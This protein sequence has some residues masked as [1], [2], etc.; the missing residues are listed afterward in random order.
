MI[1]PSPRRR[2]LFFLAGGVS[3]QAAMWVQA[4]TVA[5]VGISFLETD[6]AEIDRLEAAA[7][8]LPVLLVVP[9]GVLADRVRRGSALAVLGLLNA[10]VLASLS[11]AVWFQVLTLPHLAVAAAV[12]GLTWLAGDLTQEA[13][14]PAAVGRDRLILVN[15][16]LLCT[17]TLISFTEPL[18]EG[19]SGLVALGD[20]RSMATAVLAV[21][22]VASAASA[23]L[24]RGVGVAEEPPR[25]WTGWRRETAEGV[26]FTLTHPVLRAITVC[27]TVPVLLEAVVDE[28]ARLPRDRRDDE[29]VLIDLLSVLDDGAPL[30]G[31]VAAALLYRRVGALR[32]AWLAVLTTQPFMLL[33]ALTG[34]EGGRIWY[35]LGG[36]VPW[37]GWTVVTLVLLSHRQ[38]IT[39][40]RLLGRTGVTL[41]VFGILAEVAGALLEVLVRPLLPAV[42]FGQVL[43]PPIEIGGLAPPEFLVRAVL[44]A[45]CTAG[46]VAAALP[47]RKA[48]RPAGS[49][50]PE[51]PPAPPEDSAPPAAAP[52]APPGA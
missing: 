15:A 24:F 47:L 4:Y 31:A 51:D 14:L 9:L 48:L 28:A 43:E 16:A 39:P 50:S 22:A 12:L 13:Y 5:Q 46:T 18:A 8:L 7:A 44:L 3:R 1:S 36:A 49:V 6:P 34:L 25:P 38:A 21:M 23:P 42:F 17:A 29:G 45:L 41:L 52:A 11:A 2:S 40:A 10:G 37:A 20:P 33:Y 32:L 26:R 19:R 27:L 30:I 35:L